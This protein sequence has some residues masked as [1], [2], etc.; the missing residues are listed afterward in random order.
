MSAATRTPTP[1]ATAYDTTLACACGCGL[2]GGGSC[3]AAALNAKPEARAPDVGGSEPPCTYG[4]GGGGPYAGTG[5]ATGAFGIAI[6]DD[7]GA[8]GPSA[9]TASGGGACGIVV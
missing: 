5:A 4:T 1:A 3:A 2:V 8:D 7:N 9:A 6:V